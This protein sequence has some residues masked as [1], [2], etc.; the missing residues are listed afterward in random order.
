MSSNREAWE[1]DEDEDLELERG[2]QGSV[3]VLRPPAE[4]PWTR[5]RDLD[6]VEKE[7]FYSRLATI[8]GIRTLPSIGDWILIQV[9]HPADVARKVNRRLFPGVLSVPRNVPGTV[10]L[11]IAD[12]KSNELLYQTIRDIVA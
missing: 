2:S 6:P 11:H 12:P 4:N 1:P 10:R 8:P 9:P 7:R 5:D 3:P